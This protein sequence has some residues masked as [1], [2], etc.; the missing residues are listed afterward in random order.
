MTIIP[1]NQESA[2][3][4]L[5]SFMEESLSLQTSMEESDEKIQGLMHKM[6]QTINAISLKNQKLKEGIATLKTRSGNEHRLFQ[7][8]I[9]AACESLKKQ[10]E[11]RMQTFYYA[12]F[13]GGPIIRHQHYSDVGHMTSKLNNFET[14]Q[15]HPSIINEFKR[16]TRS[17]QLLSPEVPLPSEQPAS[18]TRLEVLTVQQEDELS[19][20][21]EMEKFSEK[22]NSLS[23]ENKELKNQLNSLKDYL[24]TQKEQHAK[25]WL[26]SLIY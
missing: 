5:N 11:I 20:H 25:K 21:D 10:K 1:F 15:Q 8:K 24:K 22:L 7:E 18:T 19:A 12:L 6:L 4:S 13:I 17:Y 26:S 2:I 9:T 3:T 23:Q 14:C 16:L